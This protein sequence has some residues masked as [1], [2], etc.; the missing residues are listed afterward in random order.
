MARKSTS[1]TARLKNSTR[2]KNMSPPQKIPTC[3]C[4]KI[5]P[6][7]LFCPQ[8]HRLRPAHIA[9]PE[10]WISRP[11]VAWILKTVNGKVKKCRVIYRYA[12]RAARFI[13]MYAHGLD[14]GEAVWA[15]RK[16]HGHRTLLL[17]TIAQLK[18][19]FVEI[20]EKQKLKI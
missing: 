11:T 17:A 19:E 2:L 12:N 4:G 15:S 6:Y 8:S 5:N 7:G 20:L 9:R 18:Q 10:T 3:Q 14:G 13:D 1:L 16:F